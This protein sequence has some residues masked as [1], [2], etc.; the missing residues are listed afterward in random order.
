MFNIRYEGP[1]LHWAE[2]TLARELDGLAVVSNMAETPDMVVLDRHSPGRLA[3]LI[4][5]HKQNV[6][7]VSDSEDWREVRIAWRGGALDFIHKREPNLRQQFEEN[8][9]PKLKALS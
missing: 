3:I 1:D 2:E 7:V 9:F 5:R 8:V 6:V 4:C